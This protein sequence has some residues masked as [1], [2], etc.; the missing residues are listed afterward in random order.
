[1][2]DRE[3]WG[4]VLTLAGWCSYAAYLAIVLS[5]LDRVRTAPRSQV[6]DSV[7]DQRL[8]LL[9]FAMIPQQIVVLAPAVAIVVL[10]GL[11]VVDA[12]PSRVLRRAVELTSF[13]A[14]AIGALD[15]VSTLLRD[16]GGGPVEWS[17]IL[18]RLGGI[19]LASSYLA[20]CRLAADESRFR[21][22]LA[23]D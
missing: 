17:E 14:V 9:S 6:F 4:R 16:N 12:G 23:N 22:S 19:L 20:V 1:M 15:I 5:T 11:D 3:R 18:L 7:W 21:S 10:T 2:I 8:E 13:V